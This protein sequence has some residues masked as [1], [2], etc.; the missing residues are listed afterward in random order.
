MPTV[1]VTT[2]G[3]DEGQQKSM[4]AQQFFMKNGFTVIRDPTQ[5]DFVLFFACGLTDPKEKHSLMMIRR[6]QAQQK[7]TARFIVWGCLTKQ[8]PKCLHG[9][10]DG[11]MIGPRDMDFFESLLGET[12]VKVDDVSGNALVLSDKTGEEEVYPKRAYDPVSAILMHIKKQMDLVR[13]PRRKGL[14]DANSYFIRV[15]DGCTGNCTYCSERPAW[16]RA[17]SKPVQKIMEEF[18]WGLQKG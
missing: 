7:D 8:N 16:G 14:F 12:T 11:P 13:L 10:Y 15:A 9:R 18:K 5:A 4:H 17:K 1:Y 2:N 3:C 6:L